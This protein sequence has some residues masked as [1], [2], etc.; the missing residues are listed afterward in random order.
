MF[1]LRIVGDLGFE[2][3]QD[4][5][6]Y[7]GRYQAS[8][9]GRIKSL[10]HYRKG[11][12]GSKV[13][14]KEKILSLKRNLTYICAILNYKCYL[15]HRLVAITFIPNP[16]NLPQV[17]HVDENK[18]NNRVENL[19]WC[20]KSYNINYGKGAINRSITS[21]KSHSGISVRI[22]QYNLDG[23]L[24]KEYSSLHEIERQYKFKR[25][26][27][28]SCCKGKLKT[29]YGFLWRYAE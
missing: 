27:I 25:S 12:N 21:K 14:Y 15:V 7:E 8:T 29:A 26:H 28:S 4:I 11:C 13:F 20:T 10:A 17:N 24:L 16:D 3:W 19:E 23:T 2:V 6:G 9:Y 22:L 18:R 1:K 5:P